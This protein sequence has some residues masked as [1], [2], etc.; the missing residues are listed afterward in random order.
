MIR[1]FRQFAA[2]AMAFAV[3]P[4]AVAD[5]ATD[6]RIANCIMRGG[7]P[8][9]CAAAV[10]APAQRP[11]PAVPGPASSAQPAALAWLGI[12]ML[13]VE[14]PEIRGVHDLGPAKAAGL[15]RHDVIIRF[16]GQP[17]RTSDDVMRRVAASA[18]GRQVE[19]VVRRNGREVR[20]VATLGRREAADRRVNDDA[21]V[22]ETIGLH[23]VTMSPLWRQRFHVEE[24]VEGAVV[25]AIDAGTPAA[26][27][28]LSETAPDTLFAGLPKS[29]PD[30]AAV[31]DVIVD[32]GSAPVKSAA[33]ARRRIDEARWKGDDDITVVVRRAD[34]QTS[35]SLNLQLLPAQAAPPPA[36]ATAR[37]PDDDGPVH[38]LLVAPVN[39]E[40]RQRL[41]LKAVRGLVITGF[42]PG[43]A[44]GWLRAGDVILEAGNEE[45]T[46]AAELR[47]RFAER[48]SA[49][50]KAVVLL[51]A[52][53][54]GD[55]QFVRFELQ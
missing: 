14:P 7:T 5:E 45:V 2:L 54:S 23:L 50:R 11:A 48:E 52:R 49:G 37:A 4:I 55:E 9:E 31:G 21:E 12:N 35:F 15:M 13:N 29:K 27:M 26:Q 8:E 34:R 53:E 1:A 10:P 28:A 41:G 30:Q 46:T 44:P 51:I 39:N 16:D 40:M 20:T 47:A 42:A 38:G 6:K 3:L 43:V 33:D 32:V 36:P 19:I 18:P 25:T 22:Q 24:G 17:V